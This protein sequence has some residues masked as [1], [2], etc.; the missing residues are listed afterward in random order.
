MRTTDAAP[1]TAIALRQAEGLWQQ[2]A[3]F[4]HQ[5]ALALQ[6]VR[7]ELQ[8]LQAGGAPLEA[9]QTRDQTQD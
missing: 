2:F 6:Q 3:V 4:R 7:Q 5:Q 9:K 8:A 1:N